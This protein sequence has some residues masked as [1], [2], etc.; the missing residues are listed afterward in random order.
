MGHQRSESEMQGHKNLLRALFY[1]PPSFIIYSSV[2]PLN[3]GK[4]DFAI[5]LFIAFIYIERTMSLLKVY[6]YE[7][8]DYDTAAAST[9]YTL[10]IVIEYLMYTSF[11]ISF[12]G[13]FS[14]FVSCFF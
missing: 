2:D 13:G 5:P 4:F 7:P 11:I 8:E 9:K 14:K 3:D 6:V 12:F 10:N 1:L